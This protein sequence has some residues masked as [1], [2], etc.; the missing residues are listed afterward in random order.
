MIPLSTNVSENY[1]P[2]DHSIWFMVRQSSL[3]LLYT[4]A[5]KAFPVH[6]YRKGVG[7]HINLVATTCGHALRSGPVTRH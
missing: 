3:V 1:E 4:V 2:P 5:D 6:L 7:T